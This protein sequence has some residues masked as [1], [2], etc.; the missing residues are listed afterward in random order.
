M[1]SDK[2]DENSVRRKPKVSYAM[3]VNVGLVGSKLSPKGVGDGKLVNIP[4]PT[5]ERD[6]GDA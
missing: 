5:I 6:W 3:F 2:T 4:I 1:S